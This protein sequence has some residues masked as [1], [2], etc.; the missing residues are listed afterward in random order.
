MYSIES[1]FNA[2]LGG[3]VYHGAARLRHVSEAFAVHVLQRSAVGVA[4][5][6]TT[7]R[8]RE[9]MSSSHSVSYVRVRRFRCVGF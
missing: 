2:R 9:S 6:A 8:R 1:L 4:W 7:G 3:G 5:R